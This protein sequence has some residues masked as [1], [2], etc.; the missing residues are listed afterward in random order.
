MQLSKL[1]GVLS[2]LNR[3]GPEECHNLVWVAVVVVGA[4]GVGADE[5]VWACGAAFAVFFLYTAVVVPSPCWHT[6]GRLPE[7]R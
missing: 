1:L 5:A 3:N 2:R 6:Q 4:V 7:V